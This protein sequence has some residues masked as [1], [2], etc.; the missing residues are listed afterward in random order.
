MPLTQN[1]APDWILRLGFWI[2]PSYISRIS[3]AEIQRWYWVTQISI[4]RLVLMYKNAY[5]IFVKISFTL[6]V[7]PFPTVL[8]QVCWSESNLPEM[9]TYDSWWRKMETSRRKIPGS[10]LQATQGSLQQRRCVSLSLAS[11]IQVHFF[12]NRFICIKNWKYSSLYLRANVAAEVFWTWSLEIL[13]RTELGDSRQKH[14]LHHPN[15][16]SI[17]FT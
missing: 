14:G 8:K 9:L 15:D 2:L 12:K 11:S 3:S 16:P 7:L 17:S 13:I 5:I 10:R 6:F 1:L 4:F